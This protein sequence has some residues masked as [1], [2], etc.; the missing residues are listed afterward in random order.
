[1]P[2]KKPPTM[3]GALFSGR[4]ASSRSLLEEGLEEDVD[5]VE[6]GSNGE[7]R[8]DR[9]RQFDHRECRLEDEVRRQDGD[10]QND[11][12]GSHAFRFGFFV[13]VQGQSS[14]EKY[15]PSQVP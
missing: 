12:E 15:Q 4:M 7:E 13:I 10:A 2:K 14:F 8:T 11:E 6:A 3:S 9:E 1:M 5:Q